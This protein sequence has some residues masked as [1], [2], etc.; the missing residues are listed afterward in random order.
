MKSKHPFCILPALSLI[1]CLMLAGCTMEDASPMPDANDLDSEVSDAEN[2]WLEAIESPRALEWIEARNAE[3]MA[4]LQEDERYADLNRSALA[5][6]TSDD[7]IPYVSHVRGDVHNFW[8]DDE[9]VKGTTCF[10]E[11]SL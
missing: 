11:K 9:H 1:A 5:I 2:L 10:G 7:R 8:Q 6:Y 4:R 3:S